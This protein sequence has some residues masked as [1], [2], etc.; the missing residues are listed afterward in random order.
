MI[1]G[2]VLILSEKIAFENEQEQTEQTRLHEAFKRAQGYSELEISQ[3][4]AALENV[5]A[6]ETLDAHVRRLT[7]IGF[8]NTQ[9]WFRCFNFTSLLTWK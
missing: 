6:P 5:L 9:Q 2:G 3:K 7:H 4:R 1:E 8:K